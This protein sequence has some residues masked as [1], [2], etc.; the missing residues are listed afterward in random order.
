MAM[1]HFKSRRHFFEELANSLTHG[2]GLIASIIATVFLVMIANGQNDAGK[3]IVGTI[4][5]SSLI[6]LY[7]AS[8]L[9]HSFQSPKAKHYLKIFDHAAIYILIAGSYTP[10]TLYAVKG[11][12]GEV[13]L[14]LIWTIA[15]LGV[16]F[17][18]FFV[19]RFKYFSTALYLGMGW[20]ALFA[21]QP[22]FEN[23]PFHGLFL[24][25]AG[26]LSYSLGVIFFL[27][28]K[29]P[30]SH[31]IWHLFVLGGSTC[32]FFAILLYVLPMKG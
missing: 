18:L 31:A 19:N 22:L 16:V 29:L 10:F 14:Y 2:A 25:V 17:K 24:L 3:I 20:L 5:G 13:M 30:F 8:T 4:Y 27:W 15:I 11:F 12:W 9:Y 6:L 28:E 7:G 1:N 26:G 32:H 23:L 21:I